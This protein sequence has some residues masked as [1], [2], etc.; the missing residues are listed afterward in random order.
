MP[1]ADG[2]CEA[3]GL[4]IESIKLRNFRAFKDVEM[5]DIPRFCVVIGANG[6]GKSSLFS[7]FGFLKG[8]LDGDVSTALA[9]LAG[10]RGFDDVV[11][12]GAKGPI[13][14]E[15][16]LREAP[17]RPLVTYSLAIG[18][19]DGRAVV[20]REA[21]KYRR[22]RSGR[23]WH[24]LDF[25]FGEGEAV[26]NEAELGPGSEEGDL[27]RERLRLSS[28]DAL[29]LK[30]LAPMGRFP[31]ATA[32]RNLIGSWHISDLD[33]GRM[34]QGGQAGQAEHLSRSGGNLPNVLQYLEARH[35]DVF[36]RMLRSLRG[37]FPR[38]TGVEAKTTEDGGIALLFQEGAS[39][40]PF[41]DRFVSDGVLYMLAYLALLNDPSP[42]PLLCV[43]GPES[44]LYPSRMEVL[45]EEF[46]LYAIRGGQAFVSTYSPDFL[47][48]VEVE[49]VFW[50]EN[51]D[52]HSTI[53]R[54]MDDRQV[55]AFMRGGDK[56]GYLW[57][58]GL[59]VGANPS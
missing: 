48:G 16:K 19:R 44:H 3:R 4:R 20:E 12:R 21:L 17:G 1:M 22:G 36:D 58:H 25:S 8:A 54:A 37:R 14:I 30:E 15:L 40:D 26:S 49:E 24:F 5:R 55:M 33:M 59:L 29:A 50:L 9:D 38:I 28:P 53:K 31:S 34:R 43:E 51:R 57:K 39:T 2:R 45:A 23:P 7:L 18:L 11:T 10:P 35:R 56:M 27:R 46:R 13:E 47:N 32:L 41:P 52:G 42:F 6:S